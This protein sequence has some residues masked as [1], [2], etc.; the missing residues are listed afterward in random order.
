MNKARR[1]TLSKIVENLRILQEELESVK[2]AEQE[3]FD[4][5]PE[6]LQYSSRG[7]DMEEAIDTLETAYDSLTDAIDSLEEF[8]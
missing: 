2:D 8:E 5:L 4:N 3:A 1:L 6:S 7:E